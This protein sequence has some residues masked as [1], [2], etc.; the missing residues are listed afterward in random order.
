MRVIT[1]TARGRRLQTLE[2]ND[3]RPTTDRVKEA[4]FSIVQ[5]ELEGRRVLDLFAGS[6]QL[7]VE[8]LSRG[9]D[10][11]VFVDASRKAVEVVKENLA[12]TG[13]ARKASVLNGDALRYL[14]TS[15]DCFDLAF[16]DPPYGTGLLQKS[17]LL[18]P[19][20]MR[21][22][23]TIVCEAPIDEALPQKVGDFTLWRSY[24]YSKVT[25]TVYRVL[26]EEETEPDE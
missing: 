10:S 22:T 11:C 12:A 3:V 13:L 21:K 26:P 1:G 25:L 8:A 18:L 24:R 6:G 19:R 9:A 16:L 4:L 17:L 15:R 20:L 7:G 14:Q 23:G 5:F 2:G